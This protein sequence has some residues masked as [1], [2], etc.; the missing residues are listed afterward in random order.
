MNNSVPYGFIDKYKVFYINCHQHSNIFILP[1]N[2]SYEKTSQTW[3]NYELNDE[4]D[5][6]Q[7]STV[8]FCQSNRAVSKSKQI[9]F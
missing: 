8:P 1:N 6:N 5:I 4:Y 2:T 7:H 9:R 3:L